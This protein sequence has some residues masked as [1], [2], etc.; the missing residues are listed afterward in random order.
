MSDVA[1]VAASYL[2]VLGGLGTYAVTIARRFRTAQR[3]TTAVALE[4]RRH[5]AESLPR[6]AGDPTTTA[7]GEAPEPT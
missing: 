7:T 2:V 5:P 1:F 6:A 4:R 3:T